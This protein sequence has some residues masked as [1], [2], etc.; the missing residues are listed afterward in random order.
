VYPAEYLAPETLPMGPGVGIETV[1]GRLGEAWTQGPVVLSWSTILDD[2]HGPRRGR[3][4]VL[5]EF[6]HVLDMSD[7]SANGTPPLGS[8]AEYRTWRA[9]MTAEFRRLHRDARRGRTLLDTYG[10]TNEAEFFAVA[11]E[12]FF[13]RPREMS[14]QLPQLY[15]LLRGFFR[16]DP[17]AWSESHRVTL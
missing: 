2:V 16:Q 4:V 13:E 10:T 6:A 14:R 1:T 7:L 9:V 17:A 3:N 15:A 5:H 11:T 8:D 12:C